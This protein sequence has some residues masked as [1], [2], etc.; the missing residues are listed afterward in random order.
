VTVDEPPIALSDQRR[1]AMAVRLLAWYDRHRRHLP[2]RAAPGDRADPYRVWLSEIM[3]QQTTVVTVKPYFDGFLARWPSVADLAAAPLDTVLSAWA[4]LGYYARARNLHKCA[5]EVVARHGGAF[6]ADEVALLALP[7]IGPYTAAAIAAIAFDQVASP[8]DGNIERVMA[9][10][11]RVETALPAAKPEIRTLAQTHTPPRRTGDYAQALMDLGATIC[12]PRKPICA[13]CP[14]QADCAA[15]AHGAP[16]TW[17][18][19]TPK[20][21]KPH[22]TGLAFLYYRGDGQVLFR[23]RP[24]QGLLGGM[25]E[26]PC[27]PWLP[28]SEAAEVDF[29]NLLK[30]APIAANWATL[31]G[32]VQH[33][34]THF[35]LAL[36]VLAAQTDARQVPVEDCFWHPLDDL[37]S[38][39]LPTVMVKVLQHGM[40][41]LR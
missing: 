33:V 34:F 7:G 38:L 16:M 31:D 26:V 25:T 32:Q 20:A 9:R 19:R 11:H 3:L 12:T 37:E 22:R 1:Q 5:Q 41:Q 6:P 24:E 39:A 40:R 30:A 13:L 17:P 27:S 14:W 23:R 21:A 8:V 28:Q 36:T 29:D 15:Y 35:S 2:W 4:G 18:R 10:I